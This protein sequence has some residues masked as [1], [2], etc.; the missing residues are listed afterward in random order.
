MIRLLICA[1]SVAC[2]SSVT[3]SAKDPAM[4]TAYREVLGSIPAAELPAMAAE[5]VKQ[6]NIRDRTT[7]TVRVTKAAVS[8]KPAAAPSVVGA[9]AR[10]VPDMAA[11]A[12]GT[13]VGEQP[14]QATVIAKAASAAAPSQAGKIVAAICRVVPKQY[15]AVAIVVAKTVP[16]SANEILRAVAS[17]VPELKEGVESA[18]AAYTGSS[19]SV[20]AILDQ[21]TGSKNKEGS[22]NSPPPRGPAFEPPFIPLSGTVKTATPGASGEVPTGGR[23]YGTP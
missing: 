11:A 20:A 12:A 1:L 23:D 9:I 13:A 2:L 18:L 17:V 5:L 4:P 6:A 14:N 3:T 7:T 10:A 8:I 15:R 19:I 21:V 16:N 22:A